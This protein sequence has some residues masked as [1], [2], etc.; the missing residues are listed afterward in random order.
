M[1]AGGQMILALL[2]CCGW[3]DGQVPPLWVFCVKVLIRL[4]LALDL[5]GKFLILNGLFVKSCFCWG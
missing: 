3:L 5:N 1:E 4:G 2:L